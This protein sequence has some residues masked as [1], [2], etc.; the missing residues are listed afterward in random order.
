[1]DSVVGFANVKMTGQSCSSADVD[2]KRTALLVLP[3]L[4]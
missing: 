2:K 4:K 1:M 3:V